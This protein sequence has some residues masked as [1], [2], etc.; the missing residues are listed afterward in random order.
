[1]ARTRA[2]LVKDSSVEHSRKRK[3]TISANVN[4]KSVKNGKKVR[5][6]MAALLAGMN[7]VC[8]WEC[9]KMV[10]EKGTFL[11]CGTNIEKLMEFRN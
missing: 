10:R 4:R 8:T 7:D 2:K 11:I 9:R 3:W 6:K 5:L 1:M